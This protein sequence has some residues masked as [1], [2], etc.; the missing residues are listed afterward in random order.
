MSMYMYSGSLNYVRNILVCG[1]VRMC[2]CVCERKC[3][4][5]CIASLNYVRIREEYTGV[6]E[7]VCESERG[8]GR[9]RERERVVCKY[10]YIASLNY[11]RNILLLA[12][13]PQLNPPSYLSPLVCRSC[14][15]PVFRN[16][17]LSVSVFLAD[18]FVCVCGFAF[19]FF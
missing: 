2:V 15:S 19:F 1:R 11:A 12:S 10:M 4:S 17:P 13:P 3:V 6:S 8:R 7:C 14:N 18:L 16:F 5:I 9:G